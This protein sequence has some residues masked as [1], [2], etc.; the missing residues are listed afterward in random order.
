ML[1]IGFLHYNT[2][3]EVDRVLIALQEIE[4]TKNN[5]LL[6]NRIDFLFGALCSR[7]QFGR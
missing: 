6:S 2:I 1:R 7:L 5:E 3:E 4:M